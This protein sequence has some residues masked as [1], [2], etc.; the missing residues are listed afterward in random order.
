[1][2][3]GSQNDKMGALWHPGPDC[4]ALGAHLAFKRRFYAI[5]VCLRGAA[6]SH[7]GHYFWLLE[8]YIFDGISNMFKDWVVTALRR[9]SSPS[10]IVLVTFRWR[11]ALVETFPPACTGG[12]FSTFQAARN[13]VFSGIPFEGARGDDFFEVSA[14]CGL[15]LSL[16]HISEP[17]TPY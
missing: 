11:S 3:H 10:G 17:T 16:I 2:P 1:M 15:R 13:T 7:F 14:Q 9:F 6:G 12:T 8:A 5:L 4:G